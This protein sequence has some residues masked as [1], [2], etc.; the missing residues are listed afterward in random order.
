MF[1]IPN[2]PFE[3]TS[4]LTSGL[5]VS[6][7]TELYIDSIV[8]VNRILALDPSPATLVPISRIMSGWNITAAMAA[9]TVDSA[10]TIRAGILR[11]II[12]AVRAG[13]ISSHGVMLNFELRTE[14]YSLTNEASLP[15]WENPRIVNMT[16]VITI[17]GTVVYIM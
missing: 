16:S 1:S 2:I 6:T 14:V 7:E 12:T 5:P 17:D 8:P 9:I 4:S 13:T 3:A 11:A 10:R 15:E